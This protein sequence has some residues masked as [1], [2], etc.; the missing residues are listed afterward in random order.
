MAEAPDRY[1]GNCGHE[2]REAGAIYF[3]L[4]TTEEKR[5]G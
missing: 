3:S 4:H 5:G 2:L 1:C